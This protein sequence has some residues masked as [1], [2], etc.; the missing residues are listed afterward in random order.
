MSRLALAPLLLLAGVA[1]AE[2]WPAWR[3]PRGD[4][5]VSDTGYPLTW[6]AAQNIKWK[7]PINGSGHSSPVVSNGKVYFA[8][9]VESEK[10]RMLH[11]VDRTTGKELWQRVAVTAELERK[12]GENSWASSTPAADGERVYVTFLDRPKLRVFCYDTAGTL[13]WET[14]PGEFHSQHG[15]SS[16]PVLYKDM[17]IV[18]GDQDAPKGQTAY[19]VALDR[20]TGA[21][22][23]RAD[24]PNKLRSYCPPTV[25]DAAGRKQLVLTGSK[26]VAGYDP[27]TGKQLWLVDGPT[28]QFVS[29]MV[30]HD[31]V[32]LLT[33]GFPKHWV[34]AIDPAG[35]GNVT[36][37][38]VL[39]SKPNE[40]GYVPSPVAHGGN[41][42][43]VDDRG[44]ASCWDVKTGTQRWKE[45]LGGV[46]H[47]ASA[48]A[49]DG[50]VYFTA[51]DGVT[52]VVR[53]SAEFE[54]LAR[55]PL[56]EKVFASPAFS[57]REVFVRGEKHLF[58]IAA[59]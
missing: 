36:K 3:G 35:S 6:T 59:R 19:I 53:A 27:D 44:V 32:L 23:W 7:F 16:P 30:L 48:V 37:S 11:C 41:L 15:F 58:C 38:H 34:M 40:G 52:T 17:V 46:G 51:D 25:V 54:V 10:Q 12:H 28:E 8:S 49:A 45:R 33:A 47:H 43:L 5:T 13:L 22:R 56:G 21:E 14:T 39:W 31:G 1:A 50:R 2:D 26:C 57:D 9:C 4:G 29:S 20:L 24:R 42:F 18:N 55:N